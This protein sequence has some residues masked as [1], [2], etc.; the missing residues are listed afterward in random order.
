MYNIDIFF[1]KGMYKSSFIN[2]TV[3]LVNKAVK[4]HFMKKVPFNKVT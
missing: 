4:V 1:D 2:E 3:Q